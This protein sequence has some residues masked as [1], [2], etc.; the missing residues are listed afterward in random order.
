MDKINLNL[1]LNRKNI[2]T[3]IINILNNFDNNIDNIEA[4]KMSLSNC[5]RYLKATT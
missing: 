5:T 4:R 1:L 3:N 2:E